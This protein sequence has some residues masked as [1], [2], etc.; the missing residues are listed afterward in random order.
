MTLIAAQPS[1]ARTYRQITTWNREDKVIEMR[2]ME[3][4]R[5]GRRIETRLM[6][7][8]LMMV[9]CTGNF[10]FRAPGHRHLVGRAAQAMAARG[11]G[12]LNS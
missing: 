8:E 5:R 6:E 2:R 11:E 9:M 10:L 3:M 4:M 1:L 7:V 12:S